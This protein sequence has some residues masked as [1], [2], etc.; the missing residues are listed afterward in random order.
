MMMV[1]N[2]LEMTTTGLI[3]NDNKTDSNCSFNKKSNHDRG[4]NYAANNDETTKCYQ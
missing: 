2:G 3:N 4:G 1:L